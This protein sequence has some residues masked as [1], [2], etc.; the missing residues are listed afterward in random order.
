MSL[1]THI[2]SKQDLIALMLDHVSGSLLV[3]EPLPTDWREALRAIA[4]R[5][6]EAYMAHPW[7]LRVFGQGIRVGPNQLRRAEQSA[8][9]VAGLGISPEDAW[10][11]LRI[12]HEWTIG[13][14]V[15]V[16]VLQEDDQLEAQLRSADPVE[17][18]QMS[19]ILPSARGQAHDT[20]FDA[21]IEVVLDGI[22]RQ[23]LER[24]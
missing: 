11:A 21:A 23:F 4:R 1:Y 19:E 17:F 6:H 3:P 18:P 5:A 22:E 8:T 12:V 20:S 2:A 15:H 7:M 10:T 16:I 24:G 9:A 13:H 14:A